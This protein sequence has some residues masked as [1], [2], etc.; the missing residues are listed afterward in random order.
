MTAAEVRVWLASHKN[1]LPYN[2]RLENHIDWVHL[3][4]ED[5]GVKVYIFEP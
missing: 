1:E 4:T 5:M 3:D 2:I